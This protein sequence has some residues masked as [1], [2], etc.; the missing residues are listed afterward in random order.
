MF[1]G[2]SPMVDKLCDFSSFHLVIHSHGPIWA[3]RAMS[4]PL[5]SMHIRR[6]MDILEQEDMRRHSWTRGEFTSSHPS[7]EPG[8][9][10]EGVG[11]SKKIVGFGVQGKWENAHIDVD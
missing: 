5:V 7:Q 10:D 6:S 3:F 4:N 11:E 2:V 9:S 8:G 1:Q